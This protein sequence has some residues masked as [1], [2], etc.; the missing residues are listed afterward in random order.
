MARKA[1]STMAADTGRRGTG[2]IA[3]IL[4]MIHRLQAEGRRLDLVRALKT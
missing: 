4:H 1:E 3:E 2:A